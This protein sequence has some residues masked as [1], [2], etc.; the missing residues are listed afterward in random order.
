MSFRA[1]ILPSGEMMYPRR[2]EIPGA[3]GDGWG[4]AEPH[5]EPYNL[6]IDFSTKATPEIIALAVRLKREIHQ[7]T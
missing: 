3:I 4:F 6:W 1:Y 2:L 5:T 7:K